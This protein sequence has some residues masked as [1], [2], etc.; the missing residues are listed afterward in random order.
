MKVSELKA[1]S[2]MQPEATLVAHGKLRVVINGKR[3]TVDRRSYRGLVAIHATSS[4]MRRWRQLRQEQK[5]ALDELGYSGQSDWPQGAV[6]G[7]AELVDAISKET[8]FR[9]KELTPLDREII[10]YDHTFFQNQSERWVWVFANARPLRRLVPCRRGRASLWPVPPTVAAKVL[11]APSGLA[12]PDERD[13]T[14]DVELITKLLETS[15]SELEEYLS[16]LHSDDLERFG[17]KLVHLGITLREQA[18]VKRA[19]SKTRK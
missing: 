7:V 4:W 8:I 15:G 10:E 2:I 11:D 1:V 5:D 12:E 18:A 17:T 13:L 16:E 9:S 3:P 6:I 19:L 14:D